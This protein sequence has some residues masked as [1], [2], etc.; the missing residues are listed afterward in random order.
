MNTA[1][2]VI[3]TANDEDVAA[4]VYFITSLPSH[5]TPSDP[6]AGVIHHVPAI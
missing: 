6:M 5:G 3:L 4:L 2:D 1:V